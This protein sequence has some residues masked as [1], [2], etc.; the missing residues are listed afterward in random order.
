MRKFNILS[1]LFCVLNGL[2]AQ[3][4]FKNQWDS[5]YRNIAEEG[6]LGTGVFW[7]L[8]MTDPSIGQFQGQPDAAE[9]DFESWM[10]FYG[11]LRESV[12]PNSGIILPE[13]EQIATVLKENLAGDVL[14]FPVLYAKGGKIEEN[15]YRNN[16]IQFDISANAWNCSDPAQCYEMQRVFISAP[17][18]K[19]LFKPAI[20][21][22]FSNNLLF[23]NSGSNILSVEAFLRDDLL[24]AFQ[25]GTPFPVNLERGENPLRFRI[26]MDDGEVFECT[27]ILAYDDR[28]LSGGIQDK[29][30]N[31]NPFRIG[32]EQGNIYA[33]P[34]RETEL[35]QRLGAFVDYLPGKTGGIQN[36]CIRKPLIIVEGVDF[37]YRN[38]ATGCYGGK[39]GSVG[40]IDLQNGYLLNPYAK[41]A[42]QREEAWKPI[43]KA[44][45]LLRELRENGYDI[46]YL[47][48]H[49]GADYIENNAMLLVKLIQDINMRKCSSEEIV[50]L[51]A[52]M[53]GLVTRYALTHM[54][55]QNMSHCVRLYISF[56]VPNK[57]ANIPLGLQAMQ[58]YLMEKTGILK[59]PFKRK[60]DRAATRQMLI[61]HIL[62]RFRSR[63]H[64]D[65]NEFIYKLEKQGNYPKLCRN[66]AVVNGS[67]T[68]AMQNFNPGDEL[69][70][71]N[72]FLGN[73]VPWVLRTV[74]AV[75]ALARPYSGI[76]G[77]SW[78]VLSIKIA[79]HPEY[80]HKIDLNTYFVDHFPG[81]I[82]YDLKDSRLLTGALNIVNKHSSAC[83]IPTFS[84]LDFHIDS[85]FRVEDFL[86]PKSPDPGIIP[87][88]AYTGAGHTNEEHMSLTDQNVAWMLRQIDMNRNELPAFL[89]SVYNLGRKERTKIGSLT[90]EN[91][92]VLQINAHNVT[93]YGSGPYDLIQPA[94]FSYEA[95]TTDCSPL[96]II[97]D[98]GELK[99]GDSNLPLANT[100]RFT[101]GKGS[102]LMLKSGS[103]LRIH[104]GS[105]LVVGEGS[106]LILH[107]GVK[108]IL[109]GSE[110][111]L[112]ID[113]TIRLEERASLTF[114]KG[115]AG[116]GG[117]IKFRNAKGGYGNGLMEIGG[118]GTSIDL[119]GDGKH[120]VV[121]QVEGRFET[122]FPG[123]T[124]KLSRLRI[125]R[126]KVMYGNRSSVVTTAPV[127]LSE[128]EFRILHW[129]P[130]GS[131][132]ALI[133]ENSPKAEIES[134]LFAGFATAVHLKGSGNNN[135]LNVLKSTFRDCVNGVLAKDAGVDIA[136][137]AFESCTAYGLYLQD[138]ESDL[139]LQ[140]SRFV[141]NK[142]GIYVFNKLSYPAHIFMNDCDILSNETGMEMDRCVTSV[143]CSRFFA[144]GTG[145]SDV[146]GELNLSTDLNFRGVI[147]EG[148]GGN[149]TFAYNSGAGIRVKGTVLHIRNG[150][151]NFIIEKNTRECRFIFGELAYSTMTHHSST[152]Y[153]L[154]AGGNYWFPGPDQNLGN[155]ARYLYFVTF[156]YPNSSGTTINLLSGDVLDDK[157]TICYSE[158][159]NPCDRV[160]NEH[161]EPSHSGGPGLAD[162]IQIYPYPV[163]DVMQVVLP[164]DEQM[165]YS[166]DLCALDGRILISTTGTGNRAE[167]DVNG[168]AKGMYI[169][170]ISTGA[171]FAIRTVLIN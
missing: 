135:K 100:G 168:L 46:F 118:K 64:D 123:Q 145:L 98:G 56:D 29:F 47:D 80:V 85:P 81:S 75:F 124:M 170:R 116:V 151:N 125:A 71:I 153:A 5:L 165:P 45:G 97:D 50:I 160:Q 14:A 150:G 169:L 162:K 89:K 49:N 113:G 15:A 147:A 93:G 60:I 103:V 158:P 90:V 131:S 30:K 110:A 37:G 8:G 96:I 65:R 102:V 48:F 134:C 115:S 122:H 146:Y 107:P 13:E 58:H 84:A 120:D 78:I 171:G 149:N 132:N 92:G 128:A 79:L 109:E 141:R 57:G 139:I 6:A 52:S 104:N 11:N 72:P 51:G 138:P 42:S 2:S 39:C 28:D 31:G 111:L 61:Y 70:S 101:L 127:H 76:D 152:P 130:M 67:L 24:G 32:D 16:V 26:H 95:S 74:G 119:E 143:S 91:G 41:K 55:K 19:T 62:S 106:K 121:L 86:D 66:I 9:A 148:K 157:N 38:A 161:T 156:P 105:S 40:L 136:H 54:E 68:G 20:Q 154:Y 1:M 140:S 7:D 3:N 59:E 43:E 117:Y 163:S 25:A 77:N 69:L 36:P 83:F 167:L 21:I 159:C 10:M 35:R 12:T 133:L 114:S 99:I 4:S 142:V 129:S 94:G 27:G 34:Q 22:L 88:S 53:G 144:N 164:G 23:G 137:S 33:E 155:S 17:F 108:I 112:Q 63:A 18:V 73:D 82:R 166:L 87:F 126:G 44:P